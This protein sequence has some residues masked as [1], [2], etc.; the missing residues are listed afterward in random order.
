[1]Y[2]NRYDNNA[3]KNDKYFGNSQFTIQGPSR[4]NNDT[5]FTAVSNNLV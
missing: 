1:M 3:I 5:K 4:L 2:R